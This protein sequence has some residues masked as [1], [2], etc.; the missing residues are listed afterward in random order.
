MK[1]NKV[2]EWLIECWTCQIAFLDCTFYKMDLYVC[3]QKLIYNCV[4]GA[5]VLFFILSFCKCT[6]NILVI[7]F[8]NIVTQ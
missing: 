7:V 8:I 4:Y 6:R 1:T 2:N 3:K 5:P